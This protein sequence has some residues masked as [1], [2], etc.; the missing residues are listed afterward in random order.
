MKFKNSDSY[1]VGE[2]VISSEEI[3]KRLNEVSLELAK[4][5][6]DKHLLL[7]GLLT[8]AAWVTID[9]HK[10]LHALN[11]TDVEVAFMKVSSYQRGTTATQDPNVEFTVS[12]NP[13]GRTILLADDIVDTGRT[14]AAVTKLLKSKKAETIQSLVLLDK[15]SRREVIYEPDYCGFVIPDIWVQGRGMD[16]DGYGRGDPNIRK[17]PYRFD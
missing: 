2:I 9:I 7:I 8:G 6:K 12:V 13:K 3:D 15:S 10:R 16:T 11:V 5:F 14:L 1:K 4:T 17:G